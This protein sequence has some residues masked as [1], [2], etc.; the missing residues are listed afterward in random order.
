MEYTEPLILTLLMM[1]LRHD[2]EL[3]QQ[4]CVT[5]KIIRKRWISL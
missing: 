5:F 2:N 1:I 4:L 3:H